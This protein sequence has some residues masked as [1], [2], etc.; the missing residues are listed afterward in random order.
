MRFL[1]SV[2]DRVGNTELL[3][4]RPFEHKSVGR[5]LFFKM[6]TFSSLYLLMQ[7]LEVGDVLP[8]NVHYALNQMVEEPTKFVYRWDQL[9][10]WTHCS[11]LCQGKA[12]ICA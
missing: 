1:A 3:H 2:Y 5:Y 8:P 11:K 4:N 12:Q 9:G 10:P 7:V 6:S